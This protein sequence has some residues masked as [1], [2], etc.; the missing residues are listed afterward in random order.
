V[1]QAW[2]RYARPALW[3]SWAPQISRVDCS[4]DR[5]TVGSTGRVYAPLGAHVNFV[6]DAYDETA[7]EWA[8]TARRGPLTLH[9]T[10][11]VTSAPGGG[12]STW[13]VSRGPLPIVFAYAPLA[14]F[15]LR[16]LVR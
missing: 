8:W 12:S 6:V 16:R 5:L 15:A 11:G 3:S 14:Q 10:H 7:R 2:E 4:T 1:E 9:L 13:L